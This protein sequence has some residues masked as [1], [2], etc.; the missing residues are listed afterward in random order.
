[1]DDGETRT[2]PSGEHAP[3]ILEILHAR[4]V[5]DRC[6][7]NSVAGVVSPRTL[8]CSNFLLHHSSRAQ[9]LL[10]SRAV[11]RRHGCSVLLPPCQ[12]PMPIIIHILALRTRRDALR[13]I[14]PMDAIPR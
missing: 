14:A 4:R 2:V 3:Q 9:M 12:C 11:L 6:L 13:Q 7:I 5:L 8:R 1:M 10:T